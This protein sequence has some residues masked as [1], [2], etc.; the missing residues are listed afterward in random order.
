MR[1]SSPVCPKKLPSR[2]RY[3]LGSAILTD[4][5][6][7]DVVV[8]AVGSGADGKAHSCIRN[9]KDRRSGWEKC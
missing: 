6:F 8:I 3:Q 7:D 1:E 5:V 2:V 4:I 9:S